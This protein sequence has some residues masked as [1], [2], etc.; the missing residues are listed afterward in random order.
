MKNKIR[1]TSFLIL[2]FFSGVINLQG[3][4]WE[5][6]QRN[7]DFDGVI[8]KAYVVVNKQ[9]TIT[10]KQL[11]AENQSNIQFIIKHSSFKNS[12]IDKGSKVIVYFSFDKHRLYSGIGNIDETTGEIY[13]SDFMKNSWSGISHN[14]CFIN[15]IKNSNRMAIRIGK[16]FFTGLSTS[17]N[18][19]FPKDHREV[20]YTETTSDF[21]LSSTSQDIGISLI[22]SKKNIDKIIV[23]SDYSLS[24]QNNIFKSDSVKIQNA[25]MIALA[26]KLMGEPKIEL[27]EKFTKYIMYIMIINRYQIS[28]IN[29]VKYNKDISSADRGHGLRIFFW[30]DS[31]KEPMYFDINEFN[32][33]DI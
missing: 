8:K 30:D 20:N 15:E 18:G 12:A 32:N 14:L 13:F 11:D 5:Y 1:N 25:V 28:T 4:V 17:F 3:Q 21:Q 22:N 10:I 29:E 26:E 27:V 33:Y 2:F 9:M 7:T 19:Y 16:I 31:Y 23:Y 6:Q 24:V